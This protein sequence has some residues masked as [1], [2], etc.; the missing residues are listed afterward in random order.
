MDLIEMTPAYNGA[1]YAFHIHCDW[2]RVIRN[3]N[4]NHKWEAREK[5]QEFRAWIRT[6][7]GY[8]IAIIHVDGETALLPLLK[9]YERHDGFQLE[10]SVPKT[11]NQNGAT[12]RS[13]G[14]MIGKA[15][16]IRID[17]KLPANLWPEFFNY[18]KYMINRLPIR[19]LKWKSPY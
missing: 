19:A 9:H 14:V 5:L 4:I 12:E 17:S 15:R 2:C 18:A 16:A 10:I 11:P 6:Q 7:F 8:D 13:G 3:Y 1:M